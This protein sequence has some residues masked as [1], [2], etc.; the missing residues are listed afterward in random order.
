[1]SPRK[2]ARYIRATLDLTD[3]LKHMNVGPLANFQLLAY[4]TQE[5]NL[6]YLLDYP[7]PDTY[8]N[9]HL[10][11][12]TTTIG[13]VSIFTL[14]TI[15]Q[16][17]YFDNVEYE[18]ISVGLVERP[19]LTLSLPLPNMEIL[20]GLTGNVS[21]PVSNTLLDTQVDFISQSVLYGKRPLSSNRRYLAVFIRGTTPETIDLNRTVLQVSIQLFD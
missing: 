14:P 16:L 4:L 3:F 12:S 17:D 2:P 20:S 19:S 5:N 6:S 15:N 18:D 8:P 21:G 1:M 11:N 10:I 7:D 9:Y 13:R